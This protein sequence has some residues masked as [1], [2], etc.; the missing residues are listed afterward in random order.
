MSDS[1]KNWLLGGGFV[2]VWGMTL[3]FL[4]WRASVHADQAIT[5]AGMVNPADVAANK[6]S[7]KDLEDRADRLDNKIER[8]VDILLED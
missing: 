1:L 5:D 3:G 7:I 8:I 6:E 4:E 2:I